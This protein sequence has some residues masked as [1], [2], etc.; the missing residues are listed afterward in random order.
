M[1]A[2]ANPLKQKAR[3]PCDPVNKDHMVSGLSRLLR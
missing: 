2:T 1:I 3:F